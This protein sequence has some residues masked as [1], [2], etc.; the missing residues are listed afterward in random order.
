MTIAITSRERIGAF[1]ALAAIAAITGSSPAA[2]QDSTFTGFKIEAIIGYDNEGVDY[3]DD[4]FT[5]GKTSQS[6]FMYGAGVGYDYQFGTWVVGIE[7]E[8]SDS[9]TSKERTFSANRPSPPVIPPIVTPVNVTVDTDT[10]G[11]F[12]IGGRAGFLVTPQT[13]LYVKGGYSNHRIAVDGTG[14]E[15]TTPFTFDDSIKVDGFRLGVG[16]EYQ[17][18]EMFYG[19]LEYRYTNYN[20][21]ELDIRGA[22]VNLDP[23]FSGIDVVRHQGVVGVGVR[24]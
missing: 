9:S 5:G 3:D 16:G 8:L 20:N 12:Y 6:G 17:F 13:L 14:T 18:N 4:F 19:K 15:G 7:A 21:G 11:D 24:F 23:L 2:A 10:G 1:G 22:N